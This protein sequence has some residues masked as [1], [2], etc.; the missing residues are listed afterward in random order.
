MIF[1]RRTQVM[2]YTIG[3]YNTP[4]PTSFRVCSTC[5]I[6]FAQ[7]FQ[8]EYTRVIY[9]QMHRIILFLLSFP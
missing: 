5:H 1:T 9:D 2:E 6:I 8:E 7:Y 3:A 4:T